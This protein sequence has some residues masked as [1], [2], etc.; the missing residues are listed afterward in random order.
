MKRFSRIVAAVLLVSMLFMTGCA[1]KQ[2][3]P[4]PSENGKMVETTFKPYGVFNMKDE[5]PNV[6]YRVS[7]GNIM[8]SVILVETVVVPIVLIGWF[9]W[10]PV[11]YLPDRGGI[12]GK[13]M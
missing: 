12:P 2:S 6:E 11:R 10:E 5:N 13:T 1:A 8:L 7:V 3:F 4:F 9:L